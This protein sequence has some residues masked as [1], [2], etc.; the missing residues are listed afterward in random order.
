VLAAEVAGERAQRRSRPPADDC[1]GRQH[2]PTAPRARSA[3]ALADGKPITRDHLPS[4]TARARGARSGR[5]SRR[6]ADAGD[7]N[8]CAETEPDPG[9][10]RAV[11]VQ[12]WSSTAGT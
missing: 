9:N 3:A 10:E 5:T 7:D 2:P 4:L 1:S 12:I 8:P 6:R 11:L